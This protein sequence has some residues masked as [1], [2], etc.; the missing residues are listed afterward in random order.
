MLG[1]GFVSIKI[2]TA[3]YA[4]PLLVGA[5]FDFWAYRIPNVVTATL[6]VLYVAC[7]LYWGVGVDWPSHLGAGLLI[8]AVGLVLFHFGV[9]GGGDIK[10]AAAVALWIGLNRDLMACFLMV[11]LFGGALT[12]VLLWLRNSLSLLALPFPGY[13]PAAL[14]PRGP[15]PY[16][17]AVAAGALWLTAQIPFLLS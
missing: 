15:V 1:D 9:F 10:L 2:I 4:G 7:A 6:A 12:L 5:A 3:V 17:V 11:G 16:G 13:L 14:R 8:L